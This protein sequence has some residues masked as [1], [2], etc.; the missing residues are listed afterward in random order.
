MNKPLNEN[1]LKELVS[2]TSE[3]LDIRYPSIIEKDYYV[4]YIIHTLSDIKNEYFQLIFSG[5]TCLSKAHKITKRMSEDIDF[6]IQLKKINNKFSKTQLL[7]ELKK[8][9]TQIIS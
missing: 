2:I 7:K 8:F 4:T 5:G 3:K 1:Q 9:R 6:K